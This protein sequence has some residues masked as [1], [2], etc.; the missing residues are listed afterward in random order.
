MT[1]KE[2]VV[3]WSDDEVTED[4][5]KKEKFKQILHYIVDRCG[6][7]PNVG[8]TVLFKL[9]YFS[10]FDYYELYEEKM[11][12][13]IYTRLPRGPAPQHFDLS[14]K[15]LEE[16]NKIKTYTADFKGYSQ[17]KYKSLKAPELTLFNQKEK[18]IIESV[19]AKCGHMNA[20]EVSNYSHEDLPYKATAD[21]DVIDYELV[22]YR[23]PAFSVK[24][25]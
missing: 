20:T 23:D 12:G 15:E 5:F 25:E 7:R 17:K 4:L 10:D 24:E 2:K 3:S 14:V 11:T 13:E 9:L 8:K 16:E 18:D 6:N 21:W 1:F 19:V 22:F